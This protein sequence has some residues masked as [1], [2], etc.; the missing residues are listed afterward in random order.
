MKEHEQNKFPLSTDEQLTIEKNNLETENVFEEPKLT[1]EELR[2]KDQLT[3]EEFLE[4]VLY[5]REEAVAHEREKRLRNEPPTKK[6]SKQ[7]RLII[8]VMSAALVISLFASF[9][10]SFNIPAIE[11]VKTSA[12]LYADEN[13]SGYKEAVVEVR[14]PGGKGTGFAIT[15]DGYILTNEH[16]IE[17]E[18]NITVSF[19]EAGVYDAAVIEAYPAIDLALLK[20]DADNLPTLLLNEEGTVE[21]EQQVLFIGNP[22]SYSH[23]ANEG[24]TI[25]PLL[26]ADWTEEV[27]MLDAPIYKGNSGSP[28]MNVKGEV[29]GVIFATTKTEEYG[30]VGLFIPIQTFYNYFPIWEEQLL[31]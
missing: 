31:Q 23:I 3:E 1:L 21:K 29:I 15:A 6:V 2:N 14:T 25:S 24:V 27:W 17:N 30:K 10:G 11:F 26:L 7:I 5:E 19:P 4:L 12:K 9:A 22:L 28:V 18:T 8:W 20:V 13:V 16:I